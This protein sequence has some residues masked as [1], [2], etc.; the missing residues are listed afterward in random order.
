[1]RVE[2]VN[3]HNKGKETWSLFWGKNLKINI[4][5]GPYIKDLVYYE[6][7]KNSCKKKEDLKGSIK[8]MHERKLNR[9]RNKVF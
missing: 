8:I 1:M 9:G 2:S 6:C 4:L 5:L 3:R 7:L